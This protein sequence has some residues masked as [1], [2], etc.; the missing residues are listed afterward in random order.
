M[1]TH[2]SA[3]KPFLCTFFG[4]VPA[5][6]QFDCLKNQSMLVSIFTEDI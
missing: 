5:S 2:D 4:F 3:T 6:S 1:F